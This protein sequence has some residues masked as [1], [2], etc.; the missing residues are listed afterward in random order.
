VKGAFLGISSHGLMNKRALFVVSVE[1]K[2]TGCNG[3][4]SEMEISLL[5]SMVFR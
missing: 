4:E 2:L 3:G 1:Q 5:L